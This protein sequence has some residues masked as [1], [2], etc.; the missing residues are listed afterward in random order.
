MPGFT[1][2]SF[3]GWEVG[4]HSL[5]EVTMGMSSFQENIHGVHLKCMVINPCHCGCM[6]LEGNIR[7]C[8]YIPTT[9]TGDT[10]EDEKKALFL[11]T[12]LMSKRDSLA[13]VSI[14]EEFEVSLNNVINNFMKFINE[15]DGRR[16]KGSCN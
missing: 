9:Y 12:T 15:T 4:E 8:R 16:S 11:L 7:G 10:E 6:S 13:Y 1:W 14:Y 3:G 5:E 2:N